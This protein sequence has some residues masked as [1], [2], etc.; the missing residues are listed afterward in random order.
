[1]CLLLLGSE[2][3]SLRGEQ[4]L[5]LQARA[6][7]PWQWQQLQPCQIFAPPPW[8]HNTSSLSFYK[9]WTLLPSAFFWDSQKPDLFIRK[10][11]YWL[12]LALFLYYNN[13]TFPPGNVNGRLKKKKKVSHDKVEKKHKD[14]NF[15]IFSVHVLP[16]DKSV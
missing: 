5:R 1:M 9:L 4:T 2:W 15:K 10:K 8:W 12:F 14:L 13:F 16:L 7:Q 11:E 3:C 6:P